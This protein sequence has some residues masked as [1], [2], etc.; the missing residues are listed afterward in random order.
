MQTTRRG[1]VSRLPTIGS[2]SFEDAFGMLRRI[3]PSSSL[4]LSLE[5]VHQRRI[6][7]PVANNNVGSQHEGVFDPLD[8]RSGQATPRRKRLLAAD[9]AIRQNWS[10][11][12]FQSHA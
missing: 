8:E 7:R 10:L 4:E 2:I 3:T 1:I 11:Q 9:A 5:A 12:R 6:C